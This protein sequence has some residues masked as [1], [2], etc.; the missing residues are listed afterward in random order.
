MTITFN[1]DG[2]AICLYGEAIDLRTLGTLTVGRASDV[3]FNEDSQE[4]EVWDARGEKRFSDASRTH[5]LR[6]EDLH[7]DEL[8]EASEWK[9]VH[10][11]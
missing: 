11:P 3:R 7:A 5:C 2:T 4:W 9:D 10:A 6:W 1:S 8:I